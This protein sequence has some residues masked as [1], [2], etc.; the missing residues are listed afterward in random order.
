MNIASSESFRKL[1][2]ALNGAPLTVPNRNIIS[3]EIRAIYKDARLKL[4]AKLTAYKASGGKFN[5]C[6]DVWTSKSQHAFLGISIHFMD[7]EFRPQ[8]YLL[9]LADLKRRH[10]GKYMAIVLVKTLQSF[11]IS[12]K[13]HSITRDNAS[14]NNTLLRAFDN[15]YHDNFGTPYTR[16]VPCIDHILNLICQDILKYLKAT[17]SERELLDITAD[18][19]EVIEED[20]TSLTESS[21][22]I[23]SPLPAI[24]QATTSKRN[25]K[26]PPLKKVKKNLVKRSK[27]APEGLNAFQKLR[28]IVGKVRL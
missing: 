20:N 6:I 17:I 11:N 21:L 16:A 12:D 24:I 23:T 9:Q 25:S 19:E 28:Y 1:V 22:T 3:G 2:I 8:N 26:P 10:T 15:Y 5:L 13:I 27:T 14:S 18:T 4:L 7:S